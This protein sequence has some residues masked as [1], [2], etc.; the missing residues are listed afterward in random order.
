MATSRSFCTAIILALSLFS[1]L[2]LAASG[3][4]EECQLSTQTVG[5]QGGT[6]HYRNAG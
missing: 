5:V 1:G 2:S 4:N 3:R 6:I